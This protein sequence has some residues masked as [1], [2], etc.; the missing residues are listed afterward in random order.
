MLEGP[1]LIEEIMLTSALCSPDVF[2]PLESVEEESG[3]NPLE[4]SSSTLQRAITKE[5]KSIQG[6][7]IKCMKILACKLLT[8]ICI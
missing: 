3:H 2:F 7:P 8:T 1:L 5:L 4:K 6:T